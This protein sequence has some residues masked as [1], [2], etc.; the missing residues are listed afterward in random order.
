MTNGL[1][2]RYYT[3]PFN[4]NRRRAA[5]IVSLLLCQDFLSRPVE[6]SEVPD[7]LD[8]DATDEAIRN[9]PACKS[10]H[11]IM[12]PLAAGLF[13]FWWFDLYDPEELNNY[14]PAR[15]NLAEKYLGVRPEWFGIPFDSPE[16]MGRLAAQDPR[17]ISCAVESFASLFWRRQPDSA[18]FLRLRF[19]QEKFKSADLRGLSL[20]REILQTPEYRAGE[21]TANA[22]AED[23]ALQRTSRQMSPDQLASSVEAL[24]GFAWTWNGYDQLDNDTLGYRVLAGGVDGWN[25]TRISESPSLTYS[26]VLEAMADAAGSW[27]VDKDFGGSEPGLLTLVDQETLPE[28]SVFTDQIVLL[29]RRLH[30]ETPAPLLLEADTALWRSIE[31]LEGPDAA[32]AS[33]IAAMIRDPAFWIY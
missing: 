22:P 1:W 4:Y 23:I 5:T 30:G 3:T 16:E 11:D 32:W 18:D 10:C 24:T 8:E 20:I 7:L 9:N 33:L 14:H 13:G 28:D 29:H 17:T 15:E 12:D 27:V 26:L 31:S 2:W 19:L 6:L 25:V 21:M